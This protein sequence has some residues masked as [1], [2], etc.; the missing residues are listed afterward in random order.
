VTVVERVVMFEG[1]GED[2]SLE[3]VLEFLRHLPD[4]QRLR[5]AEIFGVLADEVRAGAV[6]RDGDVLFV[7]SDG[8]RVVKCLHYPLVVLGVSGPVLFPSADKNVI[9]GAFSDE[10]IQMMAD[11]IAECDDSDEEKEARWEALMGDYAAELVRLFD[12]QPPD[13]FDF[14]LEV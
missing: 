5:V 8:L 10:S 11:E 13:D 14:M 12:S 2:E 1:F 3:G 4:A 7:G 6:E 9:L